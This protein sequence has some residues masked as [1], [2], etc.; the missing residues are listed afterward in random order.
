MRFFVER[1]DGS[2]EAMFRTPL[3]ALR[4]ELLGV[5]GV[6]PETA[7][8]ILLYAGNLPDLRR[9]R[10]H[11]SHLGPARLDRLR[12]RLS[13]DSGLFPDGLPADAPLYNEFHALLVRLG[14][15]FCRKT[16]PRLMGA[17]CERCS[18]RA[19]PASWRDRSLSS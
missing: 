6:G 16:R 4:E 15:D 5:H 12:R 2:V 1:Y 19:A 13:P 7:D 10:L 17:P 8:S 3:A 14:K 18:R 11:P 9:R